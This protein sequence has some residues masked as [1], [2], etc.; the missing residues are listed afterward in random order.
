IIERFEVNVHADTDSVKSTL[1]SLLPGEPIDVTGAGNSIV[2]S[3]T[4][5][6]D[7]VVARAA[8]VA[9]RFVDEDSKIVKMLRV[10][11]EQQVLLRVKVSEVS[12]TAIKQMGINWNLTDVSL[13][14]AA[15]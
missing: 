2:L 3:G 15:L 12:K 10:A 11:N 4:V 6:S 1:A 7:G 9:R 5:S 13:G 14:D 8:E